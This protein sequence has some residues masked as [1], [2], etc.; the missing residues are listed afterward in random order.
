[1]VTG[2]RRSRR[3]ALL[4]AVLI[5]A[6]WPSPLAADVPPDLAE[7]LIREIY[8]AIRDDALRPPD[9]LTLLHQTVLSAHLAVISSGVADPPPLPVVTG[10]EARDLAVVVAYVQAVLAAAPRDTDRIMASV[11]RG[12]VRTGSDLQ[13]AVFP[14]IEFTRYHRE[15]RGEHT[16]IGAQVDAVRGEIILADVTARGPAARAGLRA[17]DV[18]VEVDGRPTTGSTPDHVMDRLRG[19]TGS[20]VVIVVRR[21][22]GGVVRLSLTR[23]AAR[24]TP[25]RAKMVDPRIGYLRLLEF[26]EGASTDVRRALGGLT[27]AGAAALLLDLRDNGGGLLDEAIAIASLFLPDGIVAMEERRGALN[28][29]PIIPQARRFSGPVVVITNIFTA[30][31]SEIVAGALQ[32]TGAPLVGRRTFGKATVQT[33]YPLRGGWGLRLTTARY[34]TRRGRA[35][36]GQGLQPEV[37]VT[38]DDEQIQ[39]AA[40]VQALEATTALRARMAAGTGTRP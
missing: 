29:L 30:S 7:G 36:D 17:G 38:M 21:A 31:A 37:P 1:M 26:S 25:V 3:V 22:A 32:D 16:G 6:G 23:E 34:F 13:G 27:D 10:Q 14:P 19:D 20:L 18:I 8:E 4:V 24:E 40:D 35:I 28:P 33:I 15:L 9:L 5:A 11:L 12:M 39:G 2:H